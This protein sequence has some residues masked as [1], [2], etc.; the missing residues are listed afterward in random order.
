MGSTHSLVAKYVT[1]PIWDKLSSVKTATSGFTLGQ[2]IACAVEF[3]NQHCGIYAGDWDSY[4]DF[5]EV[6]DPL[7]QEYHGISADATTSSLSLATPTSRLLV[8]SVIGPRVAESSTTRT[9]PSS[10]GSTRKISSV[11]SQCRKEE[12]LGPSLTALPVVFKQL[13]T[14][15]KQSPERTSCWMPSTVMSIPA[16]LTSELA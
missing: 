5:A 14:V 8:W 7:I 2:A 4:K 1:K 12:T 13:E 16:P 3:D 15:S 10:P 9:R 6:F 11:S